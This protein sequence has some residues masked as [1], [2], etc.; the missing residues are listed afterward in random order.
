MHNRTAN[1]ELEGAL[2]R[3]FNL[4]SGTP[5]GSP[6]SPLL[7]ILYTADSM[8]S[9]PQHTEHG[10][11]ADDTALWTSSNTTSNLN[12]RLQQSIAAF[13]KWCGC[14]KLKLQPTK[15]ELL[16]FSVHPRRKYKYEVKVQVGNTMIKPSKATRY[17]GVIIDSQLKWIDHMQHIE[18]NV[19]PRIGL[20]RFL[21]SAAEDSND[22]IMLNLYKSLVR[23]ILVYGHAVILTAGDKIWKRLQV[24][25]NKA[26]RATLNLPKYLHSELRSIKRSQWLDFCYRLDPKNTNQFWRHSKNLFK[27]RPLGIQCFVDKNNGRILTDPAAMIDHAYEYYSES[28]TEHDSPSQNPDVHQ[29]TEHLH[30]RLAELPSKS[31]RF[32]PRIATSCL[33]K[34]PTTFK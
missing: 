30:S 19:A 7:Y 27:R 2:S 5:Q 1:I 9:M 22:K 29:F 33:K 12:K 17:L 8:N 24:L 21:S 23:T 3:T 34:K 14:W 10:L 13:D 20:L 6:L 31:L 32:K 18:R 26:I 4:K 25:Q 11:F 16:H 15:T 28:L